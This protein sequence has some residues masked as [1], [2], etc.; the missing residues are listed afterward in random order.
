[1]PLSN[2]GHDID[3]YEEDARCPAEVL[4]ER[5]AHAHALIVQA[6]D[7]IDNELLATARSLR[8]I[9]CC[10]IG[11][12]NVDVAAASRHGVTVCNAPA[13]DMIETTA[14][15]AVSLLLS[16]AKRTTRL[17]V[18]AQEGTLP[19]YSANLPMGLPVREQTTGIIGAGRI[20]TSIG[21]IM[22]SGFRNSIL[23]AG[24]SSNP[25]FERLFRAQRRSIDQLLEESDFVFVVVPLTRET[26]NLLGATRLRRLR[27]NAI[28]V[29][30]ARAGIVDDRALCELVK[31]GRIFGA[32]LDVYEPEAMHC[33]HPNLVL[34]A[35]MS[36]GENQAMRSVVKL[37]VRNTIAV[38]R[39]QAA[40]S[41]VNI[42]E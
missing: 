12:D 31:S 36:N 42:Q 35:H 18:A 15:A 37:A 23:Y 32:G 11:F 40:D 17:H 8:V 14:E 29:N 16:V 19:P 10:S 2:A 28:L 22:K 21:R 34:T 13:P 3:M 41:P 26:R 9:A 4:T 25:G 24:R 20:G 38:L 5:S 30:V 1:M 27:R 6:L 33:R 39:G 7:E